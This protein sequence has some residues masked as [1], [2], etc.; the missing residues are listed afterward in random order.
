[1]ARGRGGGQ[2]FAFDLAASPTDGTTCKPT[3]TWIS[4]AGAPTDPVIADNELFVGSET[5][6]L[7]AFTL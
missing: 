1:M 5:G 6:T 3:W 2:L 4:P 7:F